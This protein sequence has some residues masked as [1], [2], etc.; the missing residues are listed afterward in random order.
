MIRRPPRSTLFPYTTLFRSPYTDT[1]IRSCGPT[2]RAGK[3]APPI[4]TAL[5][6]ADD[7]GA[8]GEASIAI[9]NEP[10]IHFVI[11]LLPR[12]PCASSQLLSTTDPSRKT[13]H[14]LCPSGRA[15]RPTIGPLGA[16][17]TPLAASPSGPC[18][19]CCGFLARCKLTE[20]FETPRVTAEN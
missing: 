19:K 9:R 18:L 7:W 1:A 17:A 5:P 3:L 15:L 12:R 6:G 10:I 13:S 2:G 11:A 14:V 20:V 16:A 8:A 4:S